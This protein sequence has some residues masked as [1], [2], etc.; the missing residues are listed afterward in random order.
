MRNEQPHFTA[1]PQLQN[2]SYRR[3]VIMFKLIL[4]CAE[5]LASGDAA[6]VSA[7]RNF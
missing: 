3:Q 2:N 6:Y 7:K 4:K 5:I 1:V